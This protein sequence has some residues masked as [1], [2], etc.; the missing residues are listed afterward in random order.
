MAKTIQGVP[1]SLTRDQFTAFIEQFG[2]D[3]KNLVSLT[4]DVDGVHAVALDLDEDGSRAI[5]MSGNGFAKHTIDI[6][7]ID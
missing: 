7:V 2:F 3:P 6:P 1:E 4:I 5:N